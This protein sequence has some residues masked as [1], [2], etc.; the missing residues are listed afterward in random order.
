[1]ESVTLLVAFVGSVLVFSLAPVYGLIVYLV[2][3]AWY[4]SYI[5]IPLGTIDFNVGRVIIVALFISLFLQTDLPRKFRIITLDKVVIAYF[6]S[7]VLAG[8]VTAPALMG[9]LV[10]RAGAFF[11]AALPYFAVRMIIRD[12][13]QYLKLL[14]ALLVI[15]GPLAL[16]GLYQTLTGNNPVG[17]LLKYHAWK[18]ISLTREYVPENRLGFFRANV[19]FD[20]TIMF[21]LF[22]A[23]FGPVCAGLLRNVGANTRVWAFGLFLTGVGVFASMSS[24]PLLALLLAIGFLACYR[25]RQYWK[26][27]VGV[28]I[29]MCL[30]V[31]IVSNRHFYNVVDRFTFDAST[32]WY[33]SR[34]MEVALS[35]NGMAGHWLTGYG[36]EDPGW[37]ARINMTE[38]TDMVN[39]YLLVLS[40]Y[41][42]VG[43]IPFMVLIVTAWRRLFKGFWGLKHDSDRWL[44]W[45]VAGSLF[46]LFLAFF[47]VSLFGPPTTFFFVLMGFCGVMNSVVAQRGTL[48]A[49]VDRDAAK[50]IPARVISRDR[51][52]PFG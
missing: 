19:T 43:F 51:R 15:A 39:H 36:F 31:E 42:L 45:C 34:L 17:F 35:E 49:V 2:S 12:R 21:G 16:L 24:G 29:V 44:V 18:G 50:R 38:T 27:A 48:V 13:Q 40:R 11:D 22:F 25:Y 28:V 7:T 32:A 5:T 47:T 33:R 23:I 10:N 3:M 9:F 1:M 26:T 4:P 37:G 30:V 46:G 52:M 14:K 41:G 20:V 6:A 8:A